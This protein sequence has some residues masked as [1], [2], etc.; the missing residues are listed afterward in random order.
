MRTADDC[1]GHFK[2]CAQSKKTKRALGDGLNSLVAFSSN[3]F[4]GHKGKHHVRAATSLAPRPLGDGLN[5]LV[6]FFSNLFE[7]TKKKPHARR[8][9]FPSEPEVELELELDARADEEEDE[10]YEWIW[11]QWPRADHHRR[12]IPRPSDGNVPVLRFADKLR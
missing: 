12:L 5:S 1:S 6:S 8:S 10:E 7:G 9:L 2:R 4:G 3:V 11:K